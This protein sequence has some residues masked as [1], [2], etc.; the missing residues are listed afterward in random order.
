MPTRQQSLTSALK[1]LTTKGLDISLRGTSLV[2][3]FKGIPKG[4]RRN[5]GHEVTKKDV[6]EFIAEAL[7]TCSCVVLEREGFKLDQSFPL[8]GRAQWNGYPVLMGASYMFASRKSKNPTKR[9]LAGE[10]GIYFII[11]DEPQQ[12]SFFALKGWPTDEAIKDAWQAAQNDHSLLMRFLVYLQQSKVE[13]SVTEGTITLNGDVPI[14]VEGGRIVPFEES[15]P[16][17]DRVLKLVL[18]FQSPKPLSLSVA[19]YDYEQTGL[20]LG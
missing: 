14:R 16:L 8:L 13:H 3:K 9:A 4:F 10:F 12:I 18:D 11:G 19:D 7:T 1:E 5:F 2:L 6:F 17:P 20:E 15:K